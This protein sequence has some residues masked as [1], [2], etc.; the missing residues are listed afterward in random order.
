MKI[1][2]YGFYLKIHSLRDGRQV[3]FCE[4]IIEQPSTAVSRGLR[5]LAHKKT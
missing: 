3:V 4:K 5:G 1:E 2:T